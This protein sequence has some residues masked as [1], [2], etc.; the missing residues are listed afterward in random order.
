MGGIQS[1]PQIFSTCETQESIIFK[2]LQ[3]Y[4][5][6]FQ[7]IQNTLYILGELKMIEL[8]SKSKTRMMVFLPLNE[9]STSSSLVTA[10]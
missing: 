7:N 10:D 3:Q 8:V 9:A 4:F 1:F 2:H 6:D 5:D